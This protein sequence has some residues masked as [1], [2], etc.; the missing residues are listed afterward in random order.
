M[1]QD[2]FFTTLAAVG[3]K[4]LRIDKHVV[5]IP[6]EQYSTSLLARTHSYNYKFFYKFSQILPSLIFPYTNT[7]TYSY[8][9]VYD[10][11]PIVFEYVH[12]TK[13]Q[14]QRHCERM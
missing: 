14:R 12:C 3:N 7:H 9:Y 2:K 11:C 4:E 8:T 6:Y 10:D 13:F 1:I 5:L